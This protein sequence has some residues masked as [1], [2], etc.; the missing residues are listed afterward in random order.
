MDRTGVST[1]WRRFPAVYGCIIIAPLA[2]FIHTDI[3]TIWKYAPILAYMVFKPTSL[4]ES[5]TNSNY[6]W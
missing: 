3:T 4:H 2:C 6:K 5:S 1:R